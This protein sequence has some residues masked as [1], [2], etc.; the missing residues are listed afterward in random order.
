MKILDIV[1]LAILVGF[2]FGCEAEKKSRIADRIFYNGKI[3]TVNPDKP[4]A[5]AVAIRGGR[6]LKV[7]TTEEIKA[8]IG[9]L[10]E[11]LDLNGS[12]VLPGFIDSHTHFLEG[13]FA[14]SS[15]QLRQAKSKEE[16]IATVKERT[17]KIGS[18]EWILNGDW[19]QQQFD[20]PEMPR[21]EWIDPLTP[22]N[23]VFVNRL[24]GHMALANSLALEI[25]GVT[26]DTVSPHGGEII[27]DPKTGEPTGILKDGAMRLVSDKIPEPSPEEK[28]MVVSE[29]KRSI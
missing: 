11:E 22:Q 1:I 3:W 29:P 27:K 21:K 17:S 10:T 16:F 2:V 19:D 7:G 5:D 9:D 8:L 4:W 28:K 25:A 18:G 13:G 24:D 26:K 15:I 6:I 23:P 12:F 20:P 14:L